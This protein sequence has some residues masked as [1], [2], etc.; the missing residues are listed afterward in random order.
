MELARAGLSVEPCLLCGL[1]LG[2]DPG[3]G[4]VHG[5]AS[6]GGCF[7]SCDR[8]GMVGFGGFSVGV[9]ELVAQWV[10]PYLFG[11]EDVCVERA[12]FA[13]VSLVHLRSGSAGGFGALFGFD[14]AR[15]VGGEPF[16]GARG[17]AGERV[18]V[19]RRCA[20]M[21]CDAGTA[22]SCECGRCLVVFACGASPESPCHVELCLCGCL[23]VERGQV[24]DTFLH[25]DHRERF[26][27]FG[28]Y[29]SCRFC[30]GLDHGGL[31]V[32]FRLLVFVLLVEAGA[33][34]LPPCSAAIGFLRVL[35]ELR[36]V[37]V[38]EFHRAG[39]N[40]PTH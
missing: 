22:L 15:V 18:G 32:L 38:H 20:P 4:V 3:S 39:V 21:V 23:L 33:D 5:H 34:A 6:Q 35:D 19:V 25:G 26:P 30:L 37:N 31:V 24:L 2:R 10:A 29:S 17:P 14:H 36:D 12:A 13:A 40:E 27:H 11:S 1:A 16:C 28:A 9:C 8:G 7:L